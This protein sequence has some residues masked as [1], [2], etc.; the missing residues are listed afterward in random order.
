M[1]ATIRTARRTS[2]P[3]LMLFGIVYVATLAVVIAPESLRSGG[4]DR[5]PLTEKGAEDVLLRP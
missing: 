2:Y 5:A 3:A 4:Y 1:T